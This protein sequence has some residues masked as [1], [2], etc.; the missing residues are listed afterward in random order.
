M[1]QVAYMIEYSSGDQ[2]RLR[3]M[4]ALRIEII[5]TLYKYREILYCRHTRCVSRL[6]SIADKCSPCRVV[7]MLRLDPLR[8]NQM[9]LIWSP[10]SGVV[11]G[12]SKGDIC[13]HMHTWKQPR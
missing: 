12:R 9:L 11:V 10:E 6:L 2:F 13:L 4:L 7:V 3:F 1:T 8:Q 5:E